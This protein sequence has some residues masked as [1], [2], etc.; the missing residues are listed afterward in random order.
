[1]SRNAAGPAPWS[2]ILAGGDGLR[3]SGLT[4]GPD[5][6]PAPKQYCRLGGR[7]PMVRWAI[8][9]A[10]RV[11]PKRRVLIVVNEAHRR[12]W[13][14]DLADVP[15]GNLLVQPANRGTA[16]GVLL[17]LLAVQARANPLA[18][19]VF[20]PSDHFVADEDTLADSIEQAV[21]AVALD[22]AGV[23]LLGMTAA[24]S[25]QEYGW[26]LPRGG[27]GVAGVRRFVE[28]P[29]EGAARQLIRLGA[30]VNSFV[31]VA[32]AEAML[33]VFDRVL[34]DVLRAF[35][36]HVDSRGFGSLDGLYRALLPH[37]LSR[38][39]LQRAP[40]SLSVLRVPSSGWSDL[41][42]PARLLSFLGRPATA[43]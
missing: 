27:R 10:C 6:S 21:R 43:A 35:R 11:L 26:I 4:R 3:V 18:P 39:V 7:P 23:M 20:L 28:K 14:H 38:E 17:G 42:T 37:D 31:I 16:V 15:G 9:R 29:P 5:G 2:V 8:E 41:G 33:R 36:A 34:P 24:E 30:L 25:D 22:A 1:V 13:E 32:R 19:I 12:F 40:G